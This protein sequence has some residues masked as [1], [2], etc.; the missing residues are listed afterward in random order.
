MKQTARTLIK[1]LENWAYH[2]KHRKQAMSILESVESEHG[3]TDQRLIRQ[4]DEYALDTFGWK[5]Y[6]AWHANGLWLSPDYRI[7]AEREVIA[8]ASSSNRKS[9]AAARCGRFVTF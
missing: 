4:S 8:L 9:S 2:K 5:G 7:L 3:E 6:A 1:G